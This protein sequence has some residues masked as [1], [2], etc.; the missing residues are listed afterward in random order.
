[1]NLVRDC[2]AEH[3]PLPGHGPGFSCK[4]VRRQGI[5]ICS[6]RLFVSAA[7]AASPGVLTPFHFLLRPPKIANS[8]IRSLRRDQ[9]SRVLPLL[10][11]LRILVVE[12]AVSILSAG[13]TRPTEARIFGWGTWCLQPASRLLGAVVPK[14]S[15]TCLVERAWIQL[16]SN[17]FALPNGCP[18]LSYRQVSIL[19]L[20]SN[21]VGD[22]RAQCRGGALVSHPKNMALLSTCQSSTSPEHTDA[23]SP[24]LSSRDTPEKITTLKNNFVDGH[25]SAR[26]DFPSRSTSLTDSISQPLQ[27]FLAV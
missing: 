16:P 8:P 24:S 21:Q 11:L 12:D 27:V 9:Q 3:V 4:F 25:R 7:P 5:E 26:D 2:T 23:S 22:S 14:V 19:E 1:V 6:L 10:P 17:T 15:G 13:G 18:R 20:E